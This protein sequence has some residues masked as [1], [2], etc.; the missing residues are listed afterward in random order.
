MFRAHIISL[1]V[2]KKHVLTL[3]VRDRA[4]QEIIMNIINT[5]IFWEDN[6][7]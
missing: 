2:R 4:Q 6:S 3:Q 1:F 5:L 7:N